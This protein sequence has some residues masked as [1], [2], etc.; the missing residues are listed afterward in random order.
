MSG[1]IKWLTWMLVLVSF[2]AAAEGMT[3]EPGTWQMTSTVNMPMLSTPKVTTTTECI[4]EGEISPESMTE[5]MDPS[6]V[7]DTREIADNTMSW[8]LDCDTAQGKTHGEWEATSHGDT[9]S[10]EGV[11]TISVAGQEMAM[12]MSWEGERIGPCE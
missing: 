6:C 9:L 10:G 1:R 5:G 7:F 8:S 3:V 12:N 11:I 4:E 2:Q